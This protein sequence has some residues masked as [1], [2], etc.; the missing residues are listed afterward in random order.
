MTGPIVVDVPYVTE[1]SR[2]VSTVHF[3]TRSG[4]HGRVAVNRVGRHIRDLVLEI[5]RED[6]RPLHSLLGKLIAAQDAEAK[7]APDAEVWGFA[8]HRDAEGYRGRFATRDEAVAAG[9]E[10]FD[11]HAFA[12]ARG[13][14]LVAS[15]C[16]GAGVFDWLVDDMNQ[17]AG[18]HAGDLVDDWPAPEPSVEKAFDAML[19]A[20]V[21]VHM[22]K[23]DFW[24]AED[25]E[26]IP[27][28]AA[29]AVSV[30]P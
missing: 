17:R 14:Y 4:R 15:E 18:D 3:E 8:E 28:V 12:V 6:V 10:Q 23:P 16:L 1:S 29:P 27:A 5:H 7:P 25:V 30:S 26:D 9:R 11:G 19:A 2:T 13:R 20:W 21:D 22:P 24:F